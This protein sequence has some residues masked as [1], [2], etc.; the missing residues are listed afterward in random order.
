M[1]PFGKLLT[2][3][4]YNARNAGL[5]PGLLGIEIRE[6]RPGQCL[7]SM[8][9]APHHLAPTG[10]L[11][12]GSVISLADSAAGHGCMASLPEGARGF[13]TIESKTNHL[14][15]ALEGTLD[16]VATAEHLGRTTQVWSAQ[17]SHSE[18][19]RVLALFRCSQMV[20]YPR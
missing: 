8:A 13:T 4:Q 7:A 18:S 19:G 11:H 9:I 10:F 15:T 6:I 12:A 1:N 2:P 17:V 14:G 5:L 16:C 20:L 3:Q